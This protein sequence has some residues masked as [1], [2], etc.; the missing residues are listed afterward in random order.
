MEK[1]IKPKANN[2]GVTLRERTNKDG[3]TTFILDIIHNGIRK[4]EFLPNIKL[5][6]S[7]NPIDRQTNKE[8]RELAKKIA[9]KRSQELEANDYSTMT[10]AGKKTLVSVW[11]QSYIDKYTKADKRNMKGA[12]DRFNDYLLSQKITGLTFNRLTDLIVSGYRDYLLSICVGEGAASYFARFKKMVKRAYQEKLMSFNP[13]LDVKTIKGEAK[14]KDILTLDEIKLL[15]NTPTESQEVRKAF[16]FS[17]MTGLR[18]IDVKKLD[19]KS[20]NIA[21]ATM[22]VLQEKTAKTVLINLNNA[23]LQLINSSSTTEKGL[24]FDLPTANGANKTIKAWVKRAKINKEITWHNARHSFGTNLI[25]N[26]VDIL[27]ASKLLGHTSLKHTQRYVDVANEMKITA[28]NKINV[29][30]S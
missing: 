14:K 6:K 13:A 20:I 22:S 19:W 17:C 11:M 4:R 30:L 16:L 24:V 9:A 26:D 27:T 29:D 3:S 15:A 7:S 18:W 5:V 12:L 10:E 23:A 1:K 8:N 28:T 21:N 25:F 2:M